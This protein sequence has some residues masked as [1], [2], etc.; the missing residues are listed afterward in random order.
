[1]ILRGITLILLLGVMGC[2]EKPQPNIPLLDSLEQRPATV[3]DT[4]KC[5]IGEK[6]SSCATVVLP[7][8]P[9]LS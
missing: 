8:E 7:D 2:A 3:S 5:Y 4:E 9:E 6:R 1:M